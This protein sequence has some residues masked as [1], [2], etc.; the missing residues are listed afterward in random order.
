MAAPKKKP[1]ADDAKKP[2]QRGAALGA[3]PAKK[4][5]EPSLNALRR[6]RARRGR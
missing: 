1:P 5:P 6:G 2:P 4:P 3:K